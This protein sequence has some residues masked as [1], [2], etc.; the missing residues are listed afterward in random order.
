MSNRNLK[1]TKQEIICDIIENVLYASPD[2]LVSIHNLIFDE[3]PVQ[4]DRETNM[5]IEEME[6]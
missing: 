2:F 5:Y 4:Y 6:D 3:N 1:F